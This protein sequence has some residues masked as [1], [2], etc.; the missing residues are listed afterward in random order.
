MHKNDATG[1]RLERDGNATDIFAE[2]GLPAD[3]SA[4]EIG[5]EICEKLLDACMNCADCP[6]AGSCND[7]VN[8]FAAFVTAIEQRVRAK[9]G[10]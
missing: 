8:G 1:T 5:K 10:A 3:A 6:L 2:L 7:T 4:E 9:E